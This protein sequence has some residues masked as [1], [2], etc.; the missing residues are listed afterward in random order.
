MKKALLAG[1]LGGLVAFIWSAIIHMNP[2][3][4]GMGLSVFN[5]KED[6]V[7]AGLRSQNLRPALYFFPGMDMTKSMT[8]EQ[9]ATWTAKF[10]AGPAG[11]LLLRPTDGEPMDFKQL[12]VE[13]LATMLCAMIAASILTATVGSVKCRAIMVAMMGLFCWLALSVSQWNWYHFPF[14]FIAVDLLDQAIGWLL[15]GLVIAKVIKP[16]HIPAPAPAAAAS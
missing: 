8:K 11:L 3:T 4:A 2:V 12:V 10:K 7:L 9:E 15:A 14:S 1:L 6:P 13:F 16:A 5:E